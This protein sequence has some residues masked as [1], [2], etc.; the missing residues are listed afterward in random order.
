MLVV[1]DNGF[2]R[3]LTLVYLR[4]RRVEA[5]IPHVQRA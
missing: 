4:F 3:V 1:S 5:Q 2:F